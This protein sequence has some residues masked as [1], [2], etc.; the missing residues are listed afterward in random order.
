MAKETIGIGTSANDG[1][2]DPLRTAFT[3]INANFSELYGDTAEANDILD[4]TSPQLGGDLDINGW[5][6][7]SARS[8]EA[9]RVIPNGTGTIEL[10]KNTAVTGTLTVSTSLALASGATVTGILDEDAMGT[11]SA[12]QLATQQS[13]KAYV[14]STVTAQDLDFQ[15]DSGGALNIDLDSETLDI[16]GGTGIDTVGASNTLTVNIDATVATLTGSQTLTNK[17]LTSPTVSA[18]TITGTA[19]IDNLTF[20]DNIIG[21]ASNADISIT[22]GGTGDVVMGAIRLHETTFSSGDSSLIQFAENVNVTGTTTVGGT[23]NTADIATTGQ[24]TI[25]GQADIDYVR[26]KDNK[27]TTNASNANL[28]LAANGSGTIDIKNAMT[29]LG[30]TVT[31]VLTVDGSTA[32]DNLTINGN[33]ITATNSNGGIVLQPNGTGVV[34]INGDSVTMT[35]RL[36]VLSLTVN[37]DLWMAAGSK[38]TPFNTNQDVVIEASGTGSVVLD[39]VSITDNTI[40][41]HVSNANLVLDTDG[42][43]VVAVTPQLTLS[44]SFK[45]AIHTFTATDAITETEHAGR[46]CL[47]GEVGGNA[48]V[49]LTLPDAT[50]SGATYKFIVSVANTSNYVIVA[51]DASNTIGGIMLYLD[52]DG[53]A[54]TAFPTVAATDTITLNGGT[55]GGIIG[56]YLELV[57]IATDKWHVRGTMRVGAGTNPATPFSATV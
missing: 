29:T 9:I 45:Q 20:N 28:E 34:T 22:P 6:I 44:G 36:D 3:K 43:G 4:D 1:T 54:V 31:G 26:I 35:G 16:A 14:D 55:T 13:I 48:L 42:T 51:P 25:T 5:N 11:N 41:T 53:T 33:T 39:Q 38:I 46:T 40:T 17:V 15:G 10:E 12:T 24:H 30:Q 27:I 56:D 32:I 8:N 23:L 21:S 50:G 49:T 57:D 7:T 18:P 2:G 47:L 19:T 52:E 37:S